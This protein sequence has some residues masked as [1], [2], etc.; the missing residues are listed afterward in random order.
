VDPKEDL[1]NLGVTIACARGADPIGN[2]DAG[3]TVVVVS[4][5]VG[6]F[7]IAKDDTWGVALR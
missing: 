2:E 6:T 5:I 4:S 7:P 3:S 1:G